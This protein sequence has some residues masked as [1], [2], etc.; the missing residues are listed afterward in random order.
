MNA[1]TLF[2]SRETEAMEI[3]TLSAKIL[4]LLLEGDKALDACYQF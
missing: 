2:T 3:F 1:A 4:L